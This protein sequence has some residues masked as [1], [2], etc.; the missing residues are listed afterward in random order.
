VRSF[1]DKVVPDRLYLRVEVCFFMLSRVLSALLVIAL[2]LFLV[3]TSVVWTVN[4]LRFYSYEFRLQGVVEETGMSER[5]LIGVA[6][7]IREYFNSRQEPLRV[8]AVANGSFWGRTLRE[9]FNDREVAH[10]A[11]VK[12]LIWGVY[13]IQWASFAYILAWVVIAA[14]RRQRS[15]FRK[16]GVL[17]LWGC[18]LTV[19]LVAAIGIAAW[20]NFDSMFLLFHRLSFTNT[21]W[22]LDPERDYLIRIFPEGFWFDATFFI[23]L[24]T[25]AMALVLGLGTGVWLWLSGRGR[26]GLTVV[27]DRS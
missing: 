25:V 12:H 16:L 20:V 13:G 17:T 1:L 21:L 2:P 15:S 27:S 11:D 10:M 8:L 19:G 26:R 18:G 3:T 23:G 22:Q 14:V 24:A 7:Q 9:L 4:D 5:E 6:R